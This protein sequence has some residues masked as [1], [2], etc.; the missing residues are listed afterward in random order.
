MIPPTPSLTHNGTSPRRN[1]R[2]LR[3]L[4]SWSVKAHLPYLKSSSKYTITG[5]CNSTLASSEASIKTHQLPSAK[6]YGSPA[7]LAASP[8]VDLVVC[9]VRVDRHYET[10]KPALEAGKDCFVEW[11]LASNLAQATELAELAERKGVKTVIGLQGVMSPVTRRVKQLV[12]EGAIGRVVSSSVVAFMPELAGPEVFESLD[13]LNDV[14]TG[15]NVL[16]IPFGH[17]YDSVS[18]ALG[19][20]QS[21]SATLSTQFPDVA[22]KGADGSTLRT[23]KR[24]TADHVAISGLLTSGAFSTVAFNGRGLMEGD[25]KLVWRIEGDK[26]L[27]EVRG[28]S[29]FAISMTG[30]VEVRLQDFATGE[31]KDVDVAEDQSG[32][33]ANIGRLYEAFADGEWYPDWK[34]AMKRHEWVDALYKS[35][36]SGRRVSFD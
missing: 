15:G 13:Y 17:L 32:P 7:D 10:I 3:H 6:P 34:W 29:C 8:D 9:S 25:S 4:S 24:T 22:V 19:E 23:I 2:P 11:P 1:H 18:Y 33:A 21:V 27:L 12:D 14:E 20:L 35:Q 26:G 36:E 28:D 30:G 31:V 5:V 16:V